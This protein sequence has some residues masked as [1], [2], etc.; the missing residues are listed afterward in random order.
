MR[1]N[2]ENFCFHMHSI[3]SLRVKRWSYTKIASKWKTSVA[4][5]LNCE[6]VSLLQAARE[7]LWLNLP[8]TW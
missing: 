6:L 8:I 1:A 5:V 2:N 4:V 3:S 7:M